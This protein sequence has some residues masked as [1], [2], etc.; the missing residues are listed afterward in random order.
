[1]KRNREKPIKTDERASV[2]GIQRSRAANRARTAAPRPL[3]S[4]REG[5]TQ[6]KDPLGT[7]VWR[8]SGRDRAVRGV[9]K[10]SNGNYEARTQVRRAN[11]RRRRRLTGFQPPQKLTAFFA[12]ENG[13]ATM[14]RLE[15]A[16]AGGGVIQPVLRVAADNEARVPWIRRAISCAEGPTAP[17]RP[18][19]RQ[20]AGI[21]HFLCS[22][23]RHHPM[24]CNNRLPRWPSPYHS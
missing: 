10:R 6:K 21:W 15:T 19:A 7:H 18:D 23:L 2:A 14:A 4:K 16:M 17:P 9:V 1:M 5:A 22:A 24:Q 11:A 20:D 3:A 13:I 8:P 12:S